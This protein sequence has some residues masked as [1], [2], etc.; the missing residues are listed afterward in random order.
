MRKA[1]SFLLALVMLVG[2]L[3]GTAV[4]VA[5]AETGTLEAY[6]TY[7]DTT[8][9]GKLSDDAKWILKDKIGNTPVMLLCDV[10][11][12]YIG[13]QT[14]EKAA[15]FT[16]NGV[17]AQV[18]L[19]AG[20]VIANGANA[21][22][23][24]VDTLAGTAEVQISLTALGMTYDPGQTLNF[25]AKI[26][27]DSFKGTLKFAYNAMLMV[28]DFTNT[29]D[30]T[31][32]SGLNKVND[33]G[34]V[35]EEN[36]S[37][38]YKTNTMTEKGTSDTSRVGWMTERFAT[39]LDITKG[40]EMVMNVDFNDL[41]VPAADM[42]AY[43]G[44]SGFA[45]FNSMSKLFGHGF[46]ADEAGNIYVA[47]YEEAHDWAKKFDTGLDLPAKDVNIRISINDDFEA[48]IYI[49]GKCVAQFPTTSRGGVSKNSDASLYIWTSTGRRD[50]TAT[51][52]NDVVLHDMY[53][54]Q[55]APPAQLE[56]PAVANGMVV[57]DGNPNES[58]WTLN[59]SIDKTR[60][61]F[62]VDEE[63]LY[64]ALDSQESAVN[65]TFGEIKAKATLGKMPKFELGFTMGS[66]MKGNGKGQYEIAIPLKLLQQESVTGQK[67]PFGISS[68]SKSRSFEL[69]LGGGVVLKQTVYAP[70]SGDGK[71]DAVA[72]LDVAGLKMDGDI[73]DLQWYTP[74]KAAGNEKAA[75]AEFGFQWNATTLFVG[76]KIF[77][78]ARAD[79]LEL[80]IGGKALTADLQAGTASVG[81]LYQ[82]GQSLEWAIPLSELGLSG[83]N[84]ETTYEI[85]LTNA[86]GISKLYGTLKLVGTSVVIGDTA[87]DLTT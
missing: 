68:G 64:I 28:D 57:A 87:S 44:I 77:T 80:T 12:L 86:G 43:W 51:R 10:D 33:E 35:V 50:L 3:P 72:Y 8:V 24:G 42:K 27:S 40:H 83:L 47:Q 52:K 25:E 26:G 41:M 58:F 29:K 69:K 5:A 39:G 55:V 65:F 18:D 67:I 23:V 48:E 62:L 37:L 85:K 45:V 63:K 11:N 78:T 13:M 19:A 9:D 71:N 16:I 2:M 31:Y 53:I 73:K 14:A 46:I 17:T 61:G 30:K 36:G 70:V 84:A 49:N 81:T 1:T 66:E 75:G 6:Y 82:A 38:H 34:Y 15:Q 56:S 7:V 20:T 4:S 21:G 22:A 59:G 60:F 32:A 76:S 54:T 74:Y 79:K